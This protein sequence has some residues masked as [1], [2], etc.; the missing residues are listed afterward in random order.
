MA[1]N[2]N[3][4]IE[5]MRGISAIVGS[6]EGRN[7]LNR[8]RAGAPLS[9]HEREICDTHNALLKQHNEIADAERAGKSGGWLKGPR[10]Y[11]SSDAMKWI[12]N[13]HREQRRQLAAEWKAR[14]FADPTHDYWHP[15]RGALN[16]SAKLV[17]KAAYGAAETGECNNVQIG[18]DGSIN[19][20]EK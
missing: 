10:S 1:A 9:P 15:D 17:M 7:A 4:D 20:G 8:Q 3:T 16:K 14:T 6:A 19:E 11:I 18:P 12:A 13:P 2:T 5:L